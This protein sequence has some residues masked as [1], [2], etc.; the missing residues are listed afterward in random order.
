MIKKKELILLSCLRQ[1]SR[2]TLTNISKKTHIPIST[3]FD[4]LKEYEK[5]FIDK[6]TTLIDFKKLGYDIRIHIMLKIE[7][8]QRQEFEKFIV[9]SAS[10]NNVYRINNGF[11]Y[12]IEGIFKNIDDFQRFADKIENYGI[13]EITEHFVIDEL[14]RENFMSDS[15][16]IEILQ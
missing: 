11:D 2:E 14:K 7:R 1:N 6:H 12:F 4:K 15:E 16:F 9:K 10:V 8:D 5:S 13:K 3:I